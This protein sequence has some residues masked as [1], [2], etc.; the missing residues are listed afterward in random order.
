MLKLLILGAG[1]GGLTA[2]TELEPL[3]AAEKLDVTLVDSNPHFQMGFNMQWVLLGRRKPEDG[4]RSYVRRTARH[5]KFIQD[6]ITLINTANRTVTTL[7]QQLTYDYL[8]IALG[9]ELAPELIPGLKDGAINLYHHASVTQLKTAVEALQQGTLLVLISSVPFKCPPA[10]YEYALLLE[11]LLRSR[12]VREKV[13]IMLTTP[14][15]QPMPVAGK[16]VGE[17]VTAMLAERKIEYIPSIKP[18]L[19]DPLR[20]VVVYENSREIEY[21]TLSAVPPHRA[22]KVVRESGLTDPSGFIPVNLATLETSIPRVYAIGDIAGLKLPSGSPHP[23]AGMLAE[24]QATYVARK[25][26]AELGMGSPI[27]Y[28][29][30]GVC[31]VETGQG[32][33]IEVEANLLTPEGPRFNLSKPSPEGLEGKRRFETERF[34]KWFTG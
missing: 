26:A 32:M 2:A 34:E 10:P 16:A 3:A 30:S 9:A 19:V 33:A 18:K 14:E 28:T 27:E 25:I 31:Y 8:I 7:S 23:K 4:E 20:R 12:G 5:I 6:E 11:D 13:K 17:T 24:A 1:F 29:G 15:P 21:S 22:P